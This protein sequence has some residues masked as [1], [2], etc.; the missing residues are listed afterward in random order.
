[1]DDYHSFLRE[2]GE[3]II[4]CLGRWIRKNVPLLLVSDA[5]RSEIEEKGGKSN[6]CKWKARKEQYMEMSPP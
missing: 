4:S 1:M 2:K 3:V 5:Y 6:T